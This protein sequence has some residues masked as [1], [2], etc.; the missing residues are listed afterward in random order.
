MMCIMFSMAE[1]TDILIIDDDTE[2]AN[3]LK[4]LIE[5]GGATVTVA[6]SYDEGLKA[7]K[8]NP[9]L[10]IVDVMLA[11]RSGI[12]LIKE[13]HADPSITTPCI[14]LSNSVQTDHVADAIEIGVTTFLQ[15]ADHDP[16]DIAHIA[17]ERLRSLGS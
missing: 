11:E 16:E 9:R 1:Q 14:I 5:K 8:D 7:L 15:K 13:A 17:L 6:N 3:I 2:I 12:A 10:A 4:T